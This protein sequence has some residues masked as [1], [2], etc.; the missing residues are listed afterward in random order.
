MNN[1][2]KFFVISLLLSS[3]SYAYQKEINID[4][5]N[6][7]KESIEKRQN[8]MSFERSGVG[9]DIPIPQESKDMPKRS[10]FSIIKY[11]IYSNLNG[12]S[13][14]NAI[15]LNNSGG[16]IKIKPENIKAYLSDGRY[17]SPVSIEQKG[18]FSQGEQKVVILNFGEME[19]SIIGLMTRSY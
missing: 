15:I 11:D 14:I 7:V 12:R 17:I 16:G 13:T 2:M 19:E 8:V 9:N 5:L 10:Y 18:R 1:S 3:P 6:E 4:D